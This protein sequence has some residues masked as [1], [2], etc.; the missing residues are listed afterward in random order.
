M[1]VTRAS[2]FYY[3]VNTD[4]NNTVQLLTYSSSLPFHPICSSLHSTES[5]MRKT[6]NTICES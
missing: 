6:V 1:T 3:L 4:D 5:E 2:L